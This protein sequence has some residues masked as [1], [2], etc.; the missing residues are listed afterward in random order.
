MVFDTKTIYYNSQ[1]EDLGLP[2]VDIIGNISVL[3]SEVKY[4]RDMSIDGEIVPDQ[5][6]VCV[7]SQEVSVGL[8]T[9]DMTKI[10]KKYLGLL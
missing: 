4:V 5:C 3:L 6:V 9:K 7:G 1:L 8:P 2:Q 10:W